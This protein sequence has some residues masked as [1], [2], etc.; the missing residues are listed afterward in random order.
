MEKLFLIKPVLNNIDEIDDKAV[1]G[2]RLVG[3]DIIDTPYPKI[4]SEIIESVDD[5]LKTI[6]IKGKSI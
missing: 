6:F 4:T 1:Q 5:N 2:I 3:D